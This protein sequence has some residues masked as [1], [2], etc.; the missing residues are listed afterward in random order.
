M[1]RE[2]FLNKSV[3]EQIEYFNS[4]LETGMSISKI[5]KEIGISKSITEK[6]KKNGY[7]LKDNQLVCINTSEKTSSPNKTTSNK[8]KEIKK[9]NLEEVK[10]PIEKKVSKRGR[11]PKN[12]NS[13]S[14]SIIMNNELWK[15]LRIYAIKN[16]TDVS[17]ILEKL[18]L[19]FLKS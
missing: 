13:S 5:S 16:D 12:N 3:I 8:N 11:P 14:H 6:F 4:K 1:D 9:N 18:A 2:I 7:T 19:D 15:E 10:K 17:L